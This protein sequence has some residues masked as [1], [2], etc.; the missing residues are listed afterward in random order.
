ALNAEEHGERNGNK[1]ILVLAKNTSDFFHDADDH[2][3]V[4]ANA[5]ASADGIDADKKFL[6]QGIA[7]QTHVGAVFGFGGA[8]IAAELDRSRVDI[9][10]AGRLAV[11]TDVL[12]FLVAITGAHGSA[13]GGAHFPASGA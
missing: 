9:R 1:V 7:D 4:V 12:C 13:G 5:D 3:F 11:K 6:Y 10:H 8:E 2:E